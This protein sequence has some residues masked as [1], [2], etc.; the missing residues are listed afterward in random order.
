MNQYFFVLALLW[1]MSCKSKTTPETQVATTNEHTL[2]FTKEQLKSVNIAVAKPQLQFI[3]NTIRAS[4][5]IDVPPQN[6]VS[7]TVPLGGYLKY[8]KLLPGMRLKKGDVIA[9]LED[10]QYIQLQQDYLTTKAKLESAEQEFFRQKEL[11]VSKASSD[12]IYEQAKAEYQSL[13]IALSALAE[14]LRLININPATLSA[15]NISRSIR[16][17]AP[18]D[19]FVSKVNVN[20]GRYVNPSDILFDLIDPKD[21]H[22]KI[23]VFEKDLPQLSIG[24]K[25]IAHTNAHP[26]KQYNCT[27]TLI[28]KDVDT[29]RTAE[30]YCRFQ[31][32]DK[33]LLPGMYMNTII[34]LAGEESLTV[35]EQ[36]VVS[37]EG[38]NYVFTSAE[39]GTFEMTEVFIGSKEKGFVAIENKAAINNKNIVTTGAYTLLMTL[40]NK[41]EEE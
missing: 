37:F 27:I 11:N 7:V 19:G 30:V 28:S 1:M 39:N 35:P 8:T 12:K 25:L 15:Q 3:A 5:K 34:E 40:K 17:Y 26:E 14:R 13:K 21:I 16:L 10:Q 4:G 9:V 22:L 6:L 29:D 41:A 24:Q 18:F 2:T 33:S 20:I 38:K 36:A 23:R 31:D 32:Y